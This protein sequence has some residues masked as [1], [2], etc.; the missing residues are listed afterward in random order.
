[1]TLETE[2]IFS[3]ESGRFVPTE[4]AVGPWD[5]EQLHGGAPAAL[6]ARAVERLDSAVPMQLVRLT[7]EFLGPV[8]LAPL[9][10]DASVVRGGKR[11][12]QV[13]ISVTSRERTVVRARAVRL[14][15]GEVKLPRAGY[16]PVPPLP[17]PETAA[18]DQR[19]ERLFKQ[20]MFGTTG[21]E[22]RFLRGA[23]TK[24][25]PG[26]A[27]FRLRRPL[28]AGEDPSPAQRAV[29][30]ADFGNGISAALDWKKHLFIN[31]DLTVSLHRLPEG[32]WVALDARTELDGAG[33]GHAW[34]VMHDGRGTIGLGSQ[35]LFVDRQ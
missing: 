1:M 34:S 31:C 8:P 9:Q 10:V 20:D 6:I 33:V 18:S 15:T 11:L 35:S 25:G 19:W 16:A 3:C 24:P 23:F 2:P 28:V 22:V 26:A 14:R 29:A 30:A 27:W 4:H 7:L 32:E 17:G 12:Q 21:M 5:R 13:D